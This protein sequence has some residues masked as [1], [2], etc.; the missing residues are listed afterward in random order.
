MKT[1][2]ESKIELRN[3]QTLKKML[4]KSSQFLSSEQPCEPKSLDVALNIAG[5]EKY[6][7]K[8]CGDGQSGGHSIR[9]LNERSF[10]DGGNLCP[11]WL[12][13]RLTKTNFVLG[14]V[15]LDCR[16]RLLKYFF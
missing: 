14:L 6:V 1:Y 11:L 3:L 5:V 8:T 7:R 10:S 9:V 4:E 12:C 13:F 16:L 2:S 15:S